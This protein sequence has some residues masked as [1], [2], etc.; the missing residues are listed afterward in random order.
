M[1][2]A[3]GCMARCTVSDGNVCTMWGTYSNSWIPCRKILN[4]DDKLAPGI[5]SDMVNKDPDA[6]GW[7]EI[8][9]QMIP[10]MQSA[11]VHVYFGK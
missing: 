10:H 6:I 4:R 7:R 3:T 2:S 5:L 11:P 9:Q 8:V 1:N